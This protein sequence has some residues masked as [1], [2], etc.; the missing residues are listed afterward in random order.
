M[1][2]LIPAF[3]ILLSAGSSLGQSGTAQF[4]KSPNPQFINR[5]YYYRADSLSTLEQVEGSVQTKMKALGF[6]GSESIYSL[7]GSRSTI[8]IRA[9][10]TLRFALKTGT[11]MDDPSRMIRL[12]WFDSKKGSR[13]TILSSQGRFSAGKS[14]P[15]KNEIAFDVQ[16]S[17]NDVYLFIPSARLAPGEYGFM[18]VMM[19]K[20]TGTNMSYTFSAFGI[21][22]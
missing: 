4:A 2:S 15:N 18:N 1:R 19:M 3:L 13:E 20:N 11:M 12:Y 6:G 7:D 22:P 21:D 8:R 14:K 16:K 5:L 17:G 10:D 9:A